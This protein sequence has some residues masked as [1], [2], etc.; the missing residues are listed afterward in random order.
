MM[1]K[2]A[3][4][5]ATPLVRIAGRPGWDQRR[6]SHGVETQNE[7]SKREEADE[8]YMASFRAGFEFRFLFAPQGVICVVEVVARACVVVFRLGAGVLVVAW[9]ALAAETGF[10]AC[11][12]RCVGWCFEDVLAT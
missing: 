10:G 11:V 4:S 1:T 9:C 7:E 5:V 6:A 2:K 8:C 12:G 3:V